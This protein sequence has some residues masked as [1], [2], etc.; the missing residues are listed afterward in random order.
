MAFDDPAIE[1]LPCPGFIPEGCRRT[2]KQD[3]RSSHVPVILL[4]ALGDRESLLHGL[5]EYADDYLFK[6][7]E[8]DELLL[9][10]RNLIEAR[11]VAAQQ[12]ARVFGA[13]AGRPD[14]AD[15]VRASPHGPREAAF[16]GRLEK[17]AFG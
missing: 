12:A 7:C 15:P 16:L 6:P 1:W 10:V 11:R 2:L 14:P 5:E 13:G 9:R 4:T 17:I 8:L 3:E